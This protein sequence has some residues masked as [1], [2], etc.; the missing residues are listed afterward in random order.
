MFGPYNLGIFSTLYKYSVF[1]QNLILEFFQILQLFTFL[2]C[3]HTTSLQPP[4]ILW[5]QPSS[6]SVLSAQDN[7]LLLPLLGRPR[8][9]APPHV[10]ATFLD[11]AVLAF[12]NQLL[13]NLIG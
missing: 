8:A 12:L 1:D 6:L 10:V 13:R 2:L 9:F 4:L 3:L 5:L 7:K 11:T